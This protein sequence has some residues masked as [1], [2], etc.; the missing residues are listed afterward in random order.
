M[1]KVLLI[2]ERPLPIENENF[3]NGP[4]IRTWQIAKPLIDDG[5]QVCLV[6][7]NTLGGNFL[8]Q[9]IKGLDIFP[10]A[11]SEFETPDP[12]QKIHD[13]F[14]PDCI[15]SISSFLQSKAAVSLKTAKP[16]WF[17]RGDLLAE[18]QLKSS[19]DNSNDYLYYF[20]ELEKNIL[21]KGDIFSCYSLPQKFSLMGKLG[22]A[23]RLTQET[24]GYEFAHVIPCAVETGDYKLTKNIVR[25]KFAQS[26]DFLILWSGGYN[27]WA[28][29]D[30]LFSALEIAMRKNKKI[31][32][33]STGGAIPGQDERTYNKFTKQINASPYKDRYILL[34][35]RPLNDLANIYLESNLAI[36]IDK[37][38]YEVVLGSRHRI[39]D[40]MKA[41]LPIL[42]TAPSELTQ[43]LSRNQ[44]AFSFAQQQPQELA[45][46]ILDL[47]SKPQLLNEYAQRAK[48]F[49]EQEFS[50]EKT[51]RA[52]RE[53]VSRPQLAPDSLEGKKKRI[54]LPAS[55]AR[56]IE[57][58]KAQVLNLEAERE[59]VKVHVNNLNNQVNTLIAERATLNTHIRNFENER[60]QVKAHIGNLEAEREQVKI[61]LANLSKQISALTAERDTLSTHIRNLE[62]EREQVKL[63]VTGLESQ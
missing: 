35:W 39:L 3:L 48:N 54:P 38:C 46:L 32:F 21:E 25:G 18:A 19:V 57:D 55:E 51:T 59:Q 11:Q 5:H 9:K 43:S 14:Q 20:L 24:I 22:N 49:V 42:T 6:C 45:Q 16:I 8:E 60:E 29:T 12:L 4:G 26:D 62:A 44:M 37:N 63:Y 23:G 40:W 2:G 52:L 13:R 27:T 34:G 10:L 47:S 7:L 50:F 56:Q 28:D 53:W 33:V 30:T 15:V 41:R 31:K 1:S 61:H 36:N 58:L 17:D